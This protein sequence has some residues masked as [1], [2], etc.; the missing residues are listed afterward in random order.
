[1]KITMLRYAMCA[2][3][4][5]GPR[6]LRR[7][8]QLGYV[9]DGKFFRLNDAERQCSSDHEPMPRRMTGHWWVSRC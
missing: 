8:Q 4:S 7:R 2:G 5:C 1:M 6:R 9:V 3:G